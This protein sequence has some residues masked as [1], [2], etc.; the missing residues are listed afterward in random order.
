MRGT[1][2]GIEVERRGGEQARRR[3]GSLKPLQDLHY[4]KRA[5]DPASAPIFITCLTNSTTNKSLS[6]ACCFHEAER[7]QFALDESRAS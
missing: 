1:F 5:L 6:M 2:K 3:V 4:R 7:L